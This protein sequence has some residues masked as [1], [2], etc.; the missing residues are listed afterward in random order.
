MGIDLTVV[1]NAPVGPEVGAVG[2]ALKAIPPPLQANWNLS[3][4]GSKD[5][6]ALTF[7]PDETIKS[8]DV[9]LYPYDQDLIVNAA[10]QPVLKLSG[11]R[12]RICLTRAEDPNHAGQYPPLPATIH[13]VLKVSD[14]E[15]YEFT[16]PVSPG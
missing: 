7:H 12:Y 9:E 4:T 2:E 11:E 3:V 8:E 1:P 6:I 14:G 10:P 16:A 5:T 15:G 13:A